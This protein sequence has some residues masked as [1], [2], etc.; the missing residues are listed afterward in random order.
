MLTAVGEQSSRVQELRIVGD[1]TG[2]WRLGSGEIATVDQYRRQV[3]LRH[4]ISGRECQ[5]PAKARFGRLVVAA[6]VLADAEIDPHAGVAFRVQLQKVRAM[7]GR[8]AEAARGAERMHQIAQRLAVIGSCLEYAAVRRLCAPARAR[9]VERESVI[10]EQA[11]MVGGESQR[12]LVRFD[13]RRGTALF[14]QQVAEMEMR[15]GIART[16]HRRAPQRCFGL[17]RIALAKRDSKHGPGAPIAGIELEGAAAVRFGRAC[18]AA[19]P[20]GPRLAQCGAGSSLAHAVFR[21]LLAVFICR[22]RS[23]PRPARAA[24]RRSIA[25]RRS[26]RADAAAGTGASSDTTDCRRGPAASASRRRRR[27]S[28]RWGGRARPTDGRCWYTR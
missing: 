28:S 18:V 8:L 9:R 1:G 14:A 25:P 24:R 27:A 6:G 16:D 23:A 2:E 4:R 11:W 17:L 3:G 26:S 20:G 22:Y 10:V 7:R 21:T 15:V 12:T 5:G 13:G 19:L